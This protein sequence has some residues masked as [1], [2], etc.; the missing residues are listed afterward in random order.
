MTGDFS[1]D[2]Q[3]LDSSDFAK[4][5]TICRQ[6]LKSLISY[7]AFRELSTLIILPGLAITAAFTI[8]ITYD[9]REMQFQ[10]LTSLPAWPAWSAAR[11]AI[12]HFSGLYDIG[13]K[14]CVRAI[15]HLRWLDQWPELYRQSVSK[16]PTIHNKA[17]PYATFRPAPKHCTHSIKKFEF[18]I[19]I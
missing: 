10:S 19:D 2:A 14:S 12:D 8:T 15:Q 7:R 11:S 18:F 13:T 6:L 9:R 17:Q 4:V 1:K 3:S 16:R 5:D